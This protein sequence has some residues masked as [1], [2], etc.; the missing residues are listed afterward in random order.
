LPGEWP[1]AA[2][3]LVASKSRNESRGAGRRMPAQRAEELSAW[4]QLAGAE[5]AK[6]SDGNLTDL[7]I[8]E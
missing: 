3:E 2:A 1:G 5:Q 7:L 4:G 6:S 8:Y